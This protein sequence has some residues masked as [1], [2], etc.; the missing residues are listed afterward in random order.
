MYVNPSSVYL[1]EAPV[2]VVMEVDFHTMCVYKSGD[3]EKT[4]SVD[5]VVPVACSDVVHTVRSPCHVPGVDGW[6][7][8]RF[9]GAGPADPEGCVHPCGEPALR[10]M[11]QRRHRFRSV[12]SRAGAFSRMTVWPECPLSDHNG[13]P[14][15]ARS[16][17]WRLAHGSA[18]SPPSQV[19]ASLFLRAPP[20]QI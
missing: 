19:I 16:F 2:P 11:S 20:F 17:R 14:V 4:E 18:P 8:S 15:I 13:L 5:F 7:P 12:P 10:G 9:A 3:G 6:S 1:V